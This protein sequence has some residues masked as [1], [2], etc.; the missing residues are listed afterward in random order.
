MA[1]AE[2]GGTVA[3]DRNLEHVTLVIVVVETEEV[4]SEALEIIAAG[5]AADALFGAFGD[6]VVDVGLE[7]VGLEQVIVGTGDV[8]GVVAHGG[9]AEDGGEGVLVQGLVVG[10][11]VL[12]LPAETAVHAAPDRAAQGIVHGALVL[13]IS[14]TVVAPEA[15]VGT[16]AA[17]ELQTG[18][19]IQF[20]GEVGDEL[21]G[22]V[23]G[24][25]RGV[26]VGDR[27]GQFLVAGRREGIDAAVLGYDGRRVVSQ[28][29]GG[30]RLVSEDREDRVERNGGTQDGAELGVG[31]DSL[32]SDAGISDVRGEGHLVQEI[33]VR[34][35]IRNIGIVRADGQTVIV[36][37]VVVTADDTFLVE[38]TYRNEIEGLVGTAAD[39][40]LVLL[41]RGV[42]V[43]GL[44]LPVGTLAGRGNLGE[45][46]ARDDTVVDIH[47]IH[48]GHVLLGIEDFLLAPRVLPAVAAVI[49]N[50]RL[51]LGAALGGYEHDAVRSTGA[52][53]GGGSCILQDFNGLDIRR[54]EV[55]DATVDRHA[56]HD[57]E[58]VGIVDGADTTDL[59]LGAG[60]RLTGS[61]G[62]LHAGDLALE[63]IVD[64]GSFDRVELV[65]IHLGDGCRHDALLLHTVTHHDDIVEQEGVLAKNEIDDAAAV[66]GFTLGLI[67]DGGDHED[68]IG[69]DAI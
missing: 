50:G 40:E 29:L 53:N 34:G 55:V 26:Q 4:G 39:A 33:A 35:L 36:G 51:A 38:I 7:R 65:S 45:A 27:V 6:G 16:E 17:L 69:R 49:R 64:C 13:R 59:D 63:C 23:N 18:D 2:A 43:E 37:L 41:D 9:L 60:A 15:Q 5:T 61:L 58:R 54:I 19:D 57:V 48:D 30:G 67:T 46:V 31:L 11:V 1:G 47:L 24:I 21:V 28:D 20:T 3:T 52:V 62:N 12:R 42:I 32:G 8:A 66:H 10:E 14:I 56:V 68:S 25:A 44:I 22:I